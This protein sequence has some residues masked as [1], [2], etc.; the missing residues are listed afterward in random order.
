M[1]RLS[2]CLG[3]SAAWLALADVAPAA[4]AP[5]PGSEGPITDAL[6]LR[7]K[8]P[9]GAPPSVM[10]VSM[11]DAGTLEVE[12]RTMVYVT[13]IVEEIIMMDG[14]QV[15]VQR[16]VS[17]PVSQVHREKVEAKACKFFTL[18]KEGKLESLDAAKAAPMLKKSTPVLTGDRAEVD[19]R[20]FEMVKP[21]TLYV[22]VP[23]QQFLVPP[24]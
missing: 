5:T 17:E 22:V 3:L 13:K 10:A 6:R 11:P 15:K 8:M 4:P 21:G 12:R 16:A 18:G 24:P 9:P 2:M 20:H 7:E 19:P 1:I 23:P 14:K